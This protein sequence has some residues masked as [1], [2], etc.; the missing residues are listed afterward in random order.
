MTFLRLPCTTELYSRFTEKASRKLS[1]SQ[2]SFVTPKCINFEPYACSLKLKPWLLATRCRRVQM[3]GGGGDS[4]KNWV[5]GPLPN[6]RTL[7]MTKI[8]GL[9][10]PIYDL[11]KN[12]KPKF[13]PDPHSKI[14]FQTCIIIS[15][16]VQTNFRLL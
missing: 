16:V 2:S 15:F 11:T 8:Y 4:Q 10:Y 5:C 1:I 6:T 7:F 12:S 9:P 3:P 13:C 14:L